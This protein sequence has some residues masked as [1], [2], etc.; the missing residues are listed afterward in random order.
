MTETKHPFFSIILPTYNRAHLLH[1][2]IGS[3]L[4]QTFDDWELIV[5]D[6]GSKDNTKEVVEGI[7]DKRIRYIYQENAERCVA[8]N[9]GIRNAKGEFVCFIDSDDQYLPHHLETLYKSIHENNKKIGFY[10]TNVI[11]LHSEVQTKV[12]F[13][14]ASKYINNVCFVLMAKES[15][16]PARVAIHKDV[17]EIEKFDEDRSIITGEDM[18]LFVRILYKFLLF[19]INQHTVIYNLHEDNSTNIKYNHYR[20]QLKALKKIFVL[21]R[22]K[23]F[24][25][26]D[27]KNKKLSTCYS[28]I[29][30]FHEFRKEWI[31]MTKYY[32]ASIA[33]DPFNY[34][35]RWKLATI[36][37]GMKWLFYSK[38]E[39]I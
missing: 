9:N 26:K 27:V 10:V 30:R 19:Q 11:R 22:K 31:A 25:P 17:L 14:D 8:R 7:G 3:V 24:I 4:S 28:G 37:N 38:K 13:D 21:D 12:P 33:C 20:G 34:S 15:I 35:T 2:T 32:L 18:D 39:T 16:I 5:V 36:I 1:T 29:A 6:D 23:R